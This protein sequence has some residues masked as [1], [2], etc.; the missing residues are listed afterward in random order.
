MKTLANHTFAAGLTA[1]LLFACGPPNASAQALK[2]AHGELL[3]SAADGRSLVQRPNGG[4][5]ELPLPKAARINDFRSADGE[6]LVSAVSRVAGEPRLELLRGRG[7]EVEILPSPTF[8]PPAELMQPV[9]VAG[10]Q[11]VQALVW[12]AGDA[13]DRL[14]VQASRWL[15]GGWGAIETIS[16]PGKGTQIAPAT[17]VLDDGTWLVVWAAFDGRDDEILWSRF[18]G[19]AWSTPRPIAEDNAVPDVTPHLFATGGGALAAWSRYDGNDYRVNVARFDGQ[20]WSVPSVVGPAGS[21]AP[22][23]SD[24]NRPY[25]IYHR[26]VPAAWAVIELD[27]A[28]AVLG[29]ATISIAERQRPILAAVTEK[30]V[31]FEWVSRE[32]QVVS[33]PMAWVAR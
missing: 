31:T 4:R 23:F 19:G 2:T 21:T 9:F 28:G 1:L 12:L 13:H 25:L 27:A 5:V 17:A 10:D 22:G 26:A 15:N 30:A 8:A 16:P 3:L 18:A 6:W 32:R 20:G 24:A 7:D 29:E 14:A 33:A 11:G